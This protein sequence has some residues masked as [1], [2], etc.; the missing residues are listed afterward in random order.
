[1]TAL[2]KYYQEREELVQHC[3]NLKNE[4]AMLLTLSQCN[5]EIFD[6]EEDIE[7]TIEEIKMLDESHREWLNNEMDVI[8]NM[9]GNTMGN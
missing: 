9:M 2:T 6:I 7:T 8:C 5:M 1:M 3:G 4:L